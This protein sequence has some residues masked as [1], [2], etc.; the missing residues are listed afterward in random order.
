MDR[1]TSERMRFREIYPG[2]KEPDDTKGEMRDGR[3][4]VESTTT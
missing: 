2:P 4:E 1:R 3:R